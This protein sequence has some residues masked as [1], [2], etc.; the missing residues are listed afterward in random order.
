[1]SDG[2][3]GKAV[4]RK[5][6]EVFLM[7][8]LMPVPQAWVRG[9][10]NAAKLIRLLN[11]DSAVGP[12]CAN[13]NDDVAAIQYLLN[14]LFF[15]RLSTHGRGELFSS[16]IT[17]LEPSSLAQVFRARP[18]KPTGLFDGVTQTWIMMYQMQNMNLNVDGRVDPILPTQS[19]ALPTTLMALN[20]HMRAFGGGLEIR[21]MPPF[22]QSKMKPAGLMGPRD[23]DR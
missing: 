15:E 14:S 10:P 2:L 11:I 16:P 6:E 20:A 5:N 17:D 7:A 13:R 12:N 23:P 18:P 1:L 21:R 3:K 19:P 22:L 8:Y 9:N 4:G